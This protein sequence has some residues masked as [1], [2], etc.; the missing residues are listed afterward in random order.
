M[1]Y[2]LLH[3]AAEPALRPAGQPAEADHGAGRQ[4]IAAAR[5]LGNV[6][7]WQI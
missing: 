3:T 1:A 2:M 5:Q 7:L 4:D 6:Y